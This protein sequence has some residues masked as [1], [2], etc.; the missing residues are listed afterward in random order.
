[1]D[2]YLPGASTHPGWS[3]E[4]REFLATEENQF[5]TTGNISEDVSVA[6]D[7]ITTPIAGEPPLSIPM[8]SRLVYILGALTHI[9]AVS[10]DTRNREGFIDALTIALPPETFDQRAGG[11]RRRSCWPR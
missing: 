1:M 8:K 2:R 6:L 5:Q 3:D 10:A 4:I 7:G 9:E 11:P